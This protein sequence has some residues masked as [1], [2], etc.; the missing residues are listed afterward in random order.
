VQRS[1]PIQRLADGEGIKKLKAKYFYF[2]DNQGLG[3]RWCWGG[4]GRGGRTHA[5]AL[6][7]LH[8]MPRGPARKAVG[9]RNA[10]S[11]PALRK[12]RRGQSATCVTVKRCCFVYQHAR[13]RKPAM[14]H[15]G[16]ITALFPARYACDRT[17]PRMLSANDLAEIHQL[18]ALHAHAADAVPN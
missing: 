2:V 4:R 12:T 8:W 7:S 13:E 14:P 1:D 3:S 16:T 15:W 11:T 9:G 5:V 10:R 17:H 18:M 6:R